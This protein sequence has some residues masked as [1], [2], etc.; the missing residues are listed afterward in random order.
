MKKTRILSFLL[1]FAMLCG[2]A[3][4]PT[5]ADTNNADDWQLGEG[6]ELNPLTFTFKN[7]AVYGTTNGNTLKFTDPSASTANIGDWSM[8]ADVYFDESYATPDQRIYILIETVMGENY[9]IK[10]QRRN[11]AKNLQVGAEYIKSGEYSY[12]YSKVNSEKDGGIFS[13]E[14][15]TPDDPDKKHDNAAIWSNTLN[16][17]AGVNAAVSACADFRLTVQSVGGLFKVIV[18]DAINGNVLFEMVE[19]TAASYETAAV[20][21]V[22]AIV[23]QPDLSAGASSNN[24]FDINNFQTTVKSGAKS[25]AS[26]ATAD[27]ANYSW[28]DGWTHTVPGSFELKVD[29]SIAK[30]SAATSNVTIPANAGFELQYTIDV[31]KNNDDQE[32]RSTI[33]FNIGNEKVFA[34]VARRQ[35]KIYIRI[36]VYKDKT[37]HDYYNAW[38]NFFDADKK[39]KLPTEVVVNI[40]RAVG[41]NEL[42]WKVTDINGKTILTSTTDGSYV[43]LNS[44]TVG[45]DTLTTGEFKTLQFAGEADNDPSGYFGAWKYTN[46]SLKYTTDGTNYT[47]TAINDYST[48]ALNTGWDWSNGVV[49][50]NSSKSEQSLAKYELLTNTV[51]DFRIAYQTEFLTFDQQTQNNLEFKLGENTYFIRSGVRSNDNGVTWRNLYICGVT[52]GAG[53]T[54]YYADVW[55]DA[56]NYPISKLVNTTVTYDAETATLVMATSFLKDDGT[57]SWGRTVTVNNG[58]S[59]LKNGAEV[60]GMDDKNTEGYSVTMNT[61]DVVSGINFRAGKPEGVYKMNRVLIDTATDVATTGFKLVGVQDTAPAQSKINVR[62]VGV[63]DDLASFQKIGIKVDAYT[64]ANGE[65]TLH[66]NF[67]IST[68]EVYKTI[69]ANVDGV[70]TKITAEELGGNYLYALTILGVPATGTV[71]FVVTPYT[72]DVEDSSNVVDYAT[73]E[74]VYTNG[75]Y[76]SGTRV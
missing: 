50:V 49:M 52:N 73:Y 62:F 14:Y 5:V 18:S 51:G 61:T 26:Q 24:Y 57:Q 17:T 35:D 45:D 2:L 1:V 42:V 31:L 65:A 7:E 67:D 39:T 33:T 66:K 60:A 20:D 40:S 48:W 68:T 23:V 76:V 4:I 72:V 47:D 19:A 74:V 36:Q 6:W 30:T 12:F 53:Q 63:L 28:G 3:C 21:A 55:F 64:V 69:S 32:A 58:T 13:P 43:P 11:A 27:I 44:V 71:K 75:E 8:S 29:G 54:Y 10:F 25:G 22:K 38:T 46:M 15:G 59:W 56:A 34:R 16:G 9:R 37:W 70:N 41:A